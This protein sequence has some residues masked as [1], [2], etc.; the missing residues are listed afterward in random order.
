MPQQ[1][2]HEAGSV[3]FAAD[4]PHAESVNHNS[5]FGQDAAPLNRFQAVMSAWHPRAWD[6]RKLL[7]CYFA[8]I[9]GCRL[10]LRSPCSRNLH[11]ALVMMMEDG[12]SMMSFILGL[13]YLNRSNGA[14]MSL[15]TKCVTRTNQQAELVDPQASTVRH[16]EPEPTDGG[17]AAEDVAIVNAAGATE[18]Q[19]Q[20]PV[21]LFYFAM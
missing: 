7:V 14:A 18:T 8:L 17:D 13:L 11:W 16:S 9:F 12:M 10:L 3:T 6:Q 5:A 21:R 20:K 15:L 4:H 1:R 2:L 19:R